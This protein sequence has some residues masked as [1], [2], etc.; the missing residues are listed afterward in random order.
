MDLAP[1]TGI[2]QFGSAYRVMLANDSHAPGSVDRVLLDGMVRLCSQTA[3]YLY[4]RHTPTE[5]CYE[6]GARPELERHVA[7]ATQGCTRE[8]DRIEAIAAFCAALGRRAPRSLDNMV[9]GGTEE[10]IIA[11]GT[12]WCTDVARAACALCQVAGIPSRIVF[13]ADTGHA[14]SGHAI[15]EAHRAGAWGAVDAVTAVVYRRADGSPATTWDLMADPDLVERHG[16]AAY[17]TP[18]QFTSAAVA[19]YFVWESAAYDY[20]VSGVNAYYRS[21]LEMSDNGWPD[22]LRWLHGEDAESRA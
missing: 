15:V 9:L 11:R 4:S 3:E 14:Y 13:L 16:P 1:Y 6:W 8:E 20:S 21:I 5:L 19:N 2:G 17:T 22:G 7:E 18:E 10:E 12:D